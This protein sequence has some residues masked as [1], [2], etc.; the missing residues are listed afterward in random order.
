MLEKNIKKENQKKR[1]LWQPYY[2]RVVKNKK[3]YSRNAKHKG[4]QYEQ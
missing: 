3:H 4:R 2:T 1:A